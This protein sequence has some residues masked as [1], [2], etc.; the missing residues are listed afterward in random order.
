MRW[1]LEKLYTS[2]DSE[3]FKKDNEKILSS[4]EHIKKVVRGKPPNR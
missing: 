1:S 3:E 2:F 4:I